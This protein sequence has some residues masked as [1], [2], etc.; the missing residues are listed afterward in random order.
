MRR[1]LLAVGTVSAFGLACSGV[2]AAPDKNVVVVPV[3]GDPEA[4]HFCCEYTE[5]DGKRF[6]LV[7]SAQTCKAQ[8]AAKDGRWVEGPDCLPCC[9]KTQAS[10]TDPSQ[11]SNY[12][13]VTPSE[14]GG[15]CVTDDVKECDPPGG[16]RRGRRR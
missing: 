16:R 5:G 12:A 15:A 13:L 6:A 3:V 4:D 11:G 7:D 9:C 1:L 14:C 8:F 10:P 2:P